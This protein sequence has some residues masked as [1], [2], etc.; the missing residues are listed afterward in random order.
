M[1][2]IHLRMSDSISLLTLSVIIMLLSTDEF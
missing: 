2:E 1:P